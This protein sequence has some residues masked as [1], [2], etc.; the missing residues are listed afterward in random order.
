MAEKH[1]RGIYVARYRSED[2]GPLENELLRHYDARVS[3]LFALSLGLIQYYKIKTSQDLFNREKKSHGGNSIL[4][5]Y[6]GDIDHGA[7]VTAEQIR[8]CVFVHIWDSIQFVEEAD[9][10]YN[11]AKIWKAGLE[12]TDVDELLFWSFRFCGWIGYYNKLPYTLFL[13]LVD[14]SFERFYDSC[15]EWFDLLRESYEDSFG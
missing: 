1:C 3:D 8:E 9:M 13:K 10:S 15:P 6:S 12:I 11:L 4:A 7:V 5:D 2:L 14:G